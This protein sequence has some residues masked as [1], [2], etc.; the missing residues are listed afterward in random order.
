MATPLTRF[1]KIRAQVYTAT[2]HLGLDEL[3]ALVVLTGAVTDTMAAYSRA[4]LEC[5]LAEHSADW[6]AFCHEL[7]QDCARRLAMKG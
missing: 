6:R 1:K 5:A 2:R 4:D 7:A 3:Y